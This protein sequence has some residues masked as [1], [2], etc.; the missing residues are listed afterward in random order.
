[1]AFQ[2]TLKLQFD[3]KKHNYVLYNMWNLLGNKMK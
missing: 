3:N 1:M 2:P